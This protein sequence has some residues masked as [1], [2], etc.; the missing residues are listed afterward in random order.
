VI[1]VAIFDLDDTLYD[2]FGQRV[3]AAH[4]HASEA[5]VTAGV[6]ASVEAVFQARMEAFSTDPQLEHIDAEVCRRFAVRDC[7]EVTRAARAAFFSTPVGELALFPGTLP[8]LRSLHARG[9]RNFIVTFGDPATQRCKVAALG[10]DREASLERIFYTD[11][12]N[13]VRKEDVFAA[14]L[15]E[16][17]MSASEIMVVGDRP[18]AEIRAGKLLGMRTVR[19]RQGEFAA[20]EPQGPEEE[21]DFEIRSI[22]EVLNLPL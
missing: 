17:D 16:T 2:C 10:L 1:K 12:A 22:E 15:R 14:I 3:A 7:E 21:P 11:T 13:T 20:L 5:M 9:I 6:K 19:L 8:L 18:N 4:R